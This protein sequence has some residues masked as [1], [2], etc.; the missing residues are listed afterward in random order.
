MPFLFLYLSVGVDLGAVK[1]NYDTAWMLCCFE[2]SLPILLNPLPFQLG[3][4]QVS[5]TWAEST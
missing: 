3:H 1:S 4:T 5:K 2:V